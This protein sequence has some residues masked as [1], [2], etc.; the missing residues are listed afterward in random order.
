VLGPG[1]TLVFAD[2]TIDKPAPEG[3]MRRTAKSIARRT[4]SVV[5]GDHCNPDG[6]NSGVAWFVA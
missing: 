6:A 4:P 3:G 5:S 2:I 1:G